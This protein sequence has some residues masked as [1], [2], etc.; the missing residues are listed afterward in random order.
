MFF[1][2]FGLGT[3]KQHDMLLETLMVHS[4]HDAHALPQTELSDGTIGI[5]AP[6]QVA[7][8]TPSALAQKLDK[9]PP[10]LPDLKL[11]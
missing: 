2:A 6:R 10:M 9:M 3:A 1:S 11:F 4:L 7:S 5:R 8:S